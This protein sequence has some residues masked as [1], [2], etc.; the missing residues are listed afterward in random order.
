MGDEPRVGYVPSEE[1]A[2]YRELVCLQEQVT[3]EIAR[4]KNEIHALLT[5]LFPDFVQ[6]FADSTSK[7]ALEVLKAYPSTQTVVRAEPDELLKVLQD[8]CPGRY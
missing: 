2:T 1:I 8:Q 4:Y 3:T 6:V 7:S 5:V